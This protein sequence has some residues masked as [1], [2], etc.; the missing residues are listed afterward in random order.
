MRQAL[1][2]LKKDIR[3]LWIE[4]S[5][6][7]VAAGL[8]AFLGVRQSNFLT[9]ADPGRLVAALFR[10]FLL[11][12]AWL[13]LIVR[14]VYAE[15]LAGDRQFW[16]TRPYAWKSLLAAKALLMLLF[17]NLPLAAA[18]AAIVRAFGFSWSAVLP[19]LLWTQLLAAVVFEL[20]VA[21]IAALTTGVVQ[22]LLTLLI[23]CAAWVLLSTQLMSVA[24]AFAGGDW[25]AIDW[26]RTYYSLFLISIAAPAILIWQYRTRRT[27]PARVLAGAAVIVFLVLGVPFSW[28]TAYAI[29]ARL[30][31]QRVDESSL[32]AGVWAKHQWATRALINRDGSV[33]LH[34]PL[35][36]SGVP[37]GM[38]SRFD[39]LTVTIEGEGGAVWNKNE[40]PRT[41][42]SVTGQLIALQTTVDGAFYQ[43]VRDQPVR[44]RGYLYLTLFGNQRESR[45]AFD[46]RWRAV[47]GMGMCM[48]SGGNG[49]PHFLGCFSA[50]RPPSDLLSITFDTGREQWKTV[51]PVQAPSY[52]PFPAELSLDPV[53]PHLAYSTSTAPLDAATVV[54]L[55]PLAH[56][57]A[58][59]AID[60]LR[61]ADYEAHL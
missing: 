25:G 20:P 26:T 4:I 37:A 40:S 49:A 35:E 34:I 43:K 5:V 55:D 27:A 51:A 50:F 44:L 2:I 48:G 12:L 36:V 41:E 39:G 18:Q 21:A 7:L 14:A 54:S 29:E 38:E 30:S 42:M 47:P 10:P 61:L 57:R 22:F 13:T 56:V 31:R 33:S 15:T 16:P 23:A 45:M 19:G 32:H 11:L 9:R 46:K 52:S 53:T 3:Y 17:V 58:A 24:T 59:I 6:V 28:T 8:F 60:G 1:H